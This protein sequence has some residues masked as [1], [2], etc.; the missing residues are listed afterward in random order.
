[1]LDRLSFAIVGDT[2]PAEIDDTAAYPVQVIQQ[3]WSDLEAENPRPPFALMTGDYLDAHSTAGEG[4]AQLDLYLAARGRFSN[5]AF[6]VLGNHECAGDVASNCGEGGLASNNYDAFIAKMIEPLGLSTPYFAFTITGSGG[7]WTAKFVAIAANAWGPMQEAWLGQIMA[8]P[9]TYTL[10]LR[11]ERSS[12]TNAP[13]VRPSDAILAQFPYTLLLVGHTHTFQ[14]VSTER[15][16]VT[17]NGG[18][19]LSGA[20]DYGYVLAR[21][22]DDGALLFEAKDYATRQTF[23]SFAVRPDGTPTP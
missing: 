4:A 2:R 20:V 17:G 18:A 22:R 9:T 3:I 6:P 19:P 1:M 11:H 13:G 7:A 14:Y 12:V 21:Q 5:I 23:Q 16:V 15:L 10:V 8:Q